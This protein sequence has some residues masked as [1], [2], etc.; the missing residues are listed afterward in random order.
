MT[1][2]V[3]LPARDSIERDVHRALEEDI[4]SGDVLMSFAAPS[5]ST[6]VSSIV[7]W[8][9]VPVSSIVSPSLTSASNT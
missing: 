8:A 7:D 9:P 1:I 6:L 4:G 2:P 5:T 3:L